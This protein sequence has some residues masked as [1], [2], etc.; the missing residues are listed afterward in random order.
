MLLY[1]LVKKTKTCFSP[2]WDRNIH[3]FELCQYVRTY[4]YIYIYIYIYICIRTCILG[5]ITVEKKH[6][7]KITKGNKRSG[8]TALVP[9]FLGTFLPFVS[10]KYT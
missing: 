10:Q 6:V 8:R 7:R 3:E 1:I 9:C 2:T 5:C 4:V